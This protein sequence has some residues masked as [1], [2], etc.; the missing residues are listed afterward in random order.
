MSTYLLINILIISIP[1]L[2]SFERK[3]RF[4]R[5][6]P[7]VGVSVLVVG[8]A[9]LIWD[10]AATARGHWG[11]NP[12]H[13]LGIRIAG[14][15]VEEILFFVT[16][17]YACL[18]LYE[19]IRVYIREYSFPLSGWFQRSIAIVCIIAAVYFSHQPY[20]Q[21]VF[22]FTGLFF[23]LSSMLDLQMLRSN[24]FWFYIVLT[25]LPFF[26]VNYTL[27]SIPVVTY[28]D[29]AFSGIRFTTIPIE[30]FLYS[31]S[32]LGFNVLVY[33]FVIKR[34]QPHLK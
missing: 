29:F 27:T 6:L 8:T 25:Y 14:L 18:F 20:T 22:I 2:F 16:V 21:T 5:R 12:E 26:I 28:G 19:T 3:I 1:L 32:L 13:V 15:P 30:D 10:A 4:Y 31:F 24:I 23:I 9:Y 33:R 7:S 17:P 11:F 34:W